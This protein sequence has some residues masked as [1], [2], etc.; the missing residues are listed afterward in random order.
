MGQSLTC[1]CGRSEPVEESSDSKVNDIMNTIMIGKLPVK[2]IFF[3]FSFDKT[4]VYLIKS[5]NID[6]FLNT[7]FLFKFKGSNNNSC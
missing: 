7:R 5:S 1:Q 4:K 3:D 6:E 2:S